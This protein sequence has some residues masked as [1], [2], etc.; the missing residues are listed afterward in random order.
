MH[1]TLEDLSELEQSFI[2]AVYIQCKTYAQTAALLKV[3][4][5]E[6]RQLNNAL[7]PYWRPITKIRDKWKSKK[8]DGKF[9]RTSVIGTKLRNNIVIIAA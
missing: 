5:T 4:I 6:V 3:D 9:F 2:D 1:R 7:E 8:I